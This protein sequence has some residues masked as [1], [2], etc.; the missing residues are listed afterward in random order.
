MNIII[1]VHE[2]LMPRTSPGA[3]FLF[4]EEKH[5]LSLWD[6]RWEGNRPN[7]RWMPNTKDEHNY[8]NKS[9]QDCITYLINE[10][11][12]VGPFEPRGVRF[13]ITGMGMFRLKLMFINGLITITI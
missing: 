5:S 7:S 10:G 4:R 1:S 3:L 9:F 13:V 2:K 12:I 6:W 8:S 11:F